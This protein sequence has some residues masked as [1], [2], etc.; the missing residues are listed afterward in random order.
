[1][2]ERHSEDATRA[3]A[4][5]AL[6]TCAELPDLDADDR[7]LLAPLADRGLAARAVVWDDPAVDWAAYD[8]VVL[9]DPWDYVE[10]RDAFVAWAAGVP[11]LA[12]PADV[13]AWNTDKRYLGELAAAG[14]PV[15]PT[16]WVRPGDGWRSP[17]AGEFVVKPV[18]GAGSRDTGRYDAGRP[19]DRRLAETHVARL[20]A[21]GRTAMVQPY[22]AAVDTHGETALVFLGGAY[23]HAVR[24]GAMLTGPDVGDDSLYRPE[25]IAPRTPGTAERAVAER[26]LAA[27]PFPADRLL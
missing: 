14:V 25:T 23:S 16:A 15:V 9:R 17:E 6:V 10:R 27:C 26:A 18:V 2:R 11:R 7:L 1:M 21:A 20:A 19:E 5:V 12:N 22:L 13:V 3:N 8:L 24:K 4:R